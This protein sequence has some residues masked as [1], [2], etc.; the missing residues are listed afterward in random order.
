MAQLVARGPAYIDRMEFVAALL[1]TGVGVR[2]AGADL[3]AYA[4]RTLDPLSGLTMLD[5]AG[6][7]ALER[8]WHTDPGRYGSEVGSR[9]TEA[10]MART[11]VD[12]SHEIEHGM[13]TY[14]GLPGPEIS[15]HLTREASREHYGPGTEFHIG[16]ISMV[17]NTG[18]Y[19]DTPAHRYP[20]GQDLSA[21]PLSGVVDLPCVVV[22]R[23]EQAIGPEVLNG[24]D[25]EGAAVLFATGWDRHWGTEHYGAPEHPFVTG[26]AAEHLAAHGAALVGIDSVNIDDTTGGARPAHSALLA[27]GI[28]IVEHLTGLEQLVGRPARFSAVPPKV[29]GMGTFT[30]RAFAVVDP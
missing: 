17:A 10:Q 22:P 27:A 9:R 6:W 19:L 2:L 12:L 7:L 13:T 4:R 23:R 26:A 30:V 28:P 14:P 20:D 21:L 16:R 18:T 25:V 24:L 1:Y 15:D 29:R 3:T 5:V 11:L 8:R